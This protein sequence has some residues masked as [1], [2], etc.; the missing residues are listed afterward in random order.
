MNTK[1][2]VGELSYGAPTLLQ[3]DGAESAPFGARVL[4]KPLMMPAYGGP[5]LSSLVPALLAVPKERPDWLPAPLREASQV[6]LLV[7]DGLGWLQLESRAHLAP[8]MAGLDGGPI[9]SVAPTTTATALTSLALGMTPAEHGILGYKFLVDG[10]SGKEVL[11]VLRWTTVSGDARKFLAPSLLQPRPAFGG[12]E[13]PVVSRAD[14][15]GT[16]FSQAHQQGV[17]EVSWHLPSSIPLLVRGLLDQGEPFVYAYYEGV[18][19]IAHATGLGDLYGAELRF[20]DSLVSQILSV[21]PDGA[22]LGITA[23]HGQVDVGARAVVVAPEVAAESPVMSGESRFRWL[24]SW[25][26]RADV[27]L[28]RAV[29]RY[30]GEAWVAARDD[31]VGSGAL[32]GVPSE[33]AL[34][35]LGDVLVVPLGD[36]AYLD[37]A[38]PGEAKLVSR[39]GGLTPEEMLVP[40]LA[41]G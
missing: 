40:L 10:P 21:L 1:Q 38:D 6:V 35:R 9:T 7:V 41:A 25:P 26:G 37:P 28:D 12:S 11:N 24:H 13:V 34:E 32:G 17:R 16:G 18:D 36:N 8:A 23:D 33:E 4:P 3:A 29:S 19:K 2:A 20:A 27:L 5:C 31:V 22:A 15:S 30:G 39:H 14:F